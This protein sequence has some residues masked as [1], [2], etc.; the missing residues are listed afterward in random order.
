MIYQGSQQHCIQSMRIC[1]VSVVGSIEDLKRE[2]YANNKLHEVMSQ[3]DASKIPIYRSILT[4]PL[5]H[6]PLP[7]SPR[8]PAGLIDVQATF[9]FIHRER[10]G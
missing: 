4:Q 5:A 3:E 9:H 7:L 1:N 8:L 6:G 2:I 10:I